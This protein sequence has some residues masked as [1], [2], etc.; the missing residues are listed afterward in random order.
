MEQLFSILNL[1]KEKVELKDNEQ[2]ES[3]RNVLDGIGRDILRNV[4]RLY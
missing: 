2:S 4:Y 1:E 3:M